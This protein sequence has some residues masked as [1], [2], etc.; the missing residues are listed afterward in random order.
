MKIPTQFNLADMATKVLFLN[1]FYIML[2]NV[3]N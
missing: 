2:T 1:K 3:E